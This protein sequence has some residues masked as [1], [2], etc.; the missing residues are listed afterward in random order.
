MCNTKWEKRKVLAKS[1]ACAS[2]AAFPSDP[3][4]S[5]CS[6]RSFPLVP[7]DDNRCE[8]TIGPFV[9]GRKAWL[10]SDTAPGARASANLYSLVETAKAKGVEPLAYLTHLYSNLLAA[11]I[12]RTS[13]R[14]CH[15]T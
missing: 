8:N 13:R 10:F 5:C 9:V 2:K 7:L 12:A 6:R 11:T 3:T 14:C 1:E 15:G 4:A